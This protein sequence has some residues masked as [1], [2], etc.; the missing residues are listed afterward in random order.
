MRKN[1]LAML[2]IASLNAYASKVV[3]VDNFEQIEIELKTLSDGD[4][5][6]TNS[7]SSGTYPYGSAIYKVISSSNCQSG[8]DIRTM[9]VR[10]EK[11]CAEL[12]IKTEMELE[13]FGVEKVSVPDECNDETKDSTKQINAALDKVSTLKVNGLYCASKLE[14][15]SKPNSRQ[16]IIGSNPLIAGFYS[17]NIQAS[18]NTGITSFVTTNEQRSFPI[19]LMNL[20]LDARQNHDVVLGVNWF[21][22]YHSD[23]ILSGAK[24]TTLNIKSDQGTIVNNVFKNITFKGNVSKAH[25]FVKNATDWHL[26]GGT[27]EST[28]SVNL[29]VDSD[30]LA[31]VLING[32][33]FNGKVIIPNNSYGSRIIS[34]QIEDL[35]I[36]ASSGFGSG[37][38]GPNNKIKKLNVT[39]GDNRI[40]LVRSI[41]NTISSLEFNS[42][43]GGSKGV[44]FVSH[45]DDIGQFPDSQRSTDQYIFKKSKVNYRDVTYNLCGD[46]NSGDFSNGLNSK[47][48]GCQ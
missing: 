24:T 4:F 39:P 38:I 28:S 37:Q 7:Y 21:F 17:T 48:Y 18:T 16:S 47:I 23:L 27:F 20:T 13:A 29:Q 14:L 44:R 6:K 5:I 45:L 25:M 1:I 9:Q 36:S 11:V 19:T 35:N 32:V 30:S 43:T 2:M 15:K 12:V 42:E 41:S 8:I 33:K 26:E 3:V 40:N 34:N 22:G 31:G 10:S 46:F